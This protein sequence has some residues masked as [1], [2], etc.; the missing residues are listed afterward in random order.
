MSTYT[1]I[2]LLNFSHKTNLTNLCCFLYSF[3]LVISKS[4]LSKRLLILQCDAGHLFGDLIAC[5]RYRIDDER[6]KAFRLRERNEYEGVAHVLSIVHLPRRV[7]SR[8]RK[9]FSFVGFQGG[10][11]ISAHIDDIHVSA[12]SGLNLNDAMSAPISQLFY[13]GNFKSV[14]EIDPDY[15]HKA[16]KA[17]ECASIKDESPV[18]PEVLVD[19]DIAQDKEGESNISEVDI[20]DVSVH[21]AESTLSDDQ[22]EEPEGNPDHIMH[23]HVFFISVQGL[24]ILRVMMP[25]LTWMTNPHC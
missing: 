13:N 18:S 9:A 2:I 7:W 1:L 4:K 15:A 6:E 3:R 12:E 21:D 14:E 8:H 11:W 17:L 23:I 10:S 16:Y 19:T 22:E 25:K 5:A 24:M 20:E